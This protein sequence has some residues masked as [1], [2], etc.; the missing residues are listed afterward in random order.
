VQPALEHLDRALALADQ[1]QMRPLRALCALERAE[2]LSEAGRRDEAR[3][4][5]APAL[6]DL[7]AMDMTAACRRSAFLLE[8]L[9]PRAGLR[10]RSS[11][12]QDGS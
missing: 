4:S 9:R 1:L 11:Q 10:R 8:N 7:R 6:D 2:I 3:R 12:E 5:L